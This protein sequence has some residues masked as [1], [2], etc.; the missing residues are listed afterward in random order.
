M[1]RLADII[2]LGDHTVE[3]LVKSMQELERLTGEYRNTDS[4]ID[5]ERIKRH[6]V[7]HLQFY[8]QQY[9]RLKAY[10][11]PN[12]TYFETQYKKLKA[13]T[14]SMLLSRGVKVTQ[15]DTLVYQEPYYA[16]RVA[17]LEKAKESF[18]HAE[19]K[20]EQFNNTLQALVQSISIA[21]KEYGNTRSAGF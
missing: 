13:E 18:I 1:V 9:S 11:G 10:K 12:H 15:A 17:V 6:F 21:N 14:M 7:A 3:N 5:L 2:P 20:Y 16:D 8:T 19:L 4:L